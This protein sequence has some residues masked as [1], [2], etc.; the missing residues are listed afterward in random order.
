MSDQI[1]PIHTACKMCAFATYDNNTQ[2]DCALG[3]IDIYRNKK[4]DILEVYDA[5]KEFYV[6]NDK[7]C[8]GYRTDASFKRFKLESETIEDKIKIYEEY[9]KLSYILVI[10]I[11]TFANKVEDL[12]S[13]LKD[14]E[15]NPQ[16]TIFAR[17]QN[18]KQLSPYSQIEDIISRSNLKNKWHVH[19]ILEPD[20]TFR[21]VLHD[22]CENNKKYRFAVSLGDSAESLSMVVNKAQ[23]IVHKDLGSFNILSDEE[24]HCVLY[25]IE[26]YRHSMFLFNIDILDNNDLYTI[27]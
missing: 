8:I 23:S 27:V 5:D 9:N 11:D 15:V 3:Y 16:K 17:Y 4:L 19:T 1:N 18:E 14:L 12:I 24:H 21:H 22:I 20:K 10:N 7:K 26:S 25:P 13:A 6:I 2:I